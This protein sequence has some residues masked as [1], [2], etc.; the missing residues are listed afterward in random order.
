MFSI[1]GEVAKVLFQYD[2]FGLAKIDALITLPTAEQWKDLFI[3]NGHELKVTCLVDGLIR[4]TVEDMTKMNTKP[5][6][7]GWF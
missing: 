1:Y 6:K 3:K 2:G 4:L 7:E 5:I